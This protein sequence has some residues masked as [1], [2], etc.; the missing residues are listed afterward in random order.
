ML[1][2]REITQDGF[3]AKVRDWNKSTLIEQ[4]RERWADH[5]NRALAERD[6]DAR[7][8]NRSLEAQGIALEP[9]DKIGP[10]ASR[11]GGRGLE[12]ERIEEHRA[13]AQRNGERIP[14]AAIDPSNAGDGPQK[15]F[16]MSFRSWIKTAL[17]KQ[18]WIIA[19]VPLDDKERTSKLV[20]LLVED[21]ADGRARRLTL[22]PWLWYERPVRERFEGHDCGLTVE[23]PV[24]LS[25]DGTG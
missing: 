14:C 1:T 5:V 7:I 21:N 12:A 2:M 17:L 18:G 11:F 24:Y 10:A 15:V 23:G 25:K 22:H 9:Q 13:I 8:D 6:I 20:E 4:W 3:G 19:R 16:Q